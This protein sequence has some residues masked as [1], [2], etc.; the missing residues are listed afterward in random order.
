VE[1]LAK[2]ENSNRVSS[3]EESYKCLRNVLEK[4]FFIMNLSKPQGLIRSSNIF[5]SGRQLELFETSDLNKLLVLFGAYGTG[6]SF[7]MQA[8]AEQLALQLQNQTSSVREVHGVA[9]EPIW[10]VLWQNKTLLLKL[11]LENK[12]K[13]L[14]GIII[15]VSIREANHIAAWSI[16]HYTFFYR[17][18]KTR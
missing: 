7:M 1:W 8:K 11:L 14:K 4:L 17:N 6:K 15:V 13:H 9:C 10:Y 16:V 3:T 5:Y 2:E 12:W 18:I